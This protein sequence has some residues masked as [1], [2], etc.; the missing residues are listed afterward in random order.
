VDPCCCIPDDSEMK[1]SELKHR[2]FGST[3]SELSTSAGSR[4]EATDD[5]L[6]C[7]VN[8]QYSGSCGFPLLVVDAEATFGVPS[9]VPQMGCSTATNGD[10]EL[11]CS[12]RCPG[13]ETTVQLHSVK[14]QPHTMSCHRE[15]EAELPVDTAGPAGPKECGV[16]VMSHQ[17]LADVDHTEG[18]L[19][20]TLAPMPPSTSCQH[21]ARSCRR[22]S[23]ADITMT[24]AGCLGHEFAN[25]PR[26]TSCLHL[27]T[28]CHRA[29]D[30]TPQHKFM[31]FC[32]DESMATTQQHKEDW[33]PED[34]VHNKFSGL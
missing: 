10:S 3:T 15:D 11:T 9:P 24:R 34:E 8:S 14:C 13:H 32:H 18:C 16:A 4:N 23:E 6:N 33:I 21:L 12:V 20:H 30:R 31:E 1:V 25:M 28:S 19:G 7:I 26:R 5:G 27:A 17:S 29:S 2:G 22:E